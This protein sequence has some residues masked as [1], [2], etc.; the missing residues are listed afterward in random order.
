MNVI[1]MVKSLHVT[2]S[3][4]II[5]IFTLVKISISLIN[6]LPTNEEAYIF[7]SMVLQ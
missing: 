1:N 6:L 7:I 5:K 2:V 3:F 4:K